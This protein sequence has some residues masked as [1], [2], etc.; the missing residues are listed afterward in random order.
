MPRLTERKRRVLIVDDHPMVREGLASMLEG[1]VGDLFQAGTGEEA[2][3]RVR[4]MRPDLVL[5]DLKL[6]DL[7]GLTVL[8]RIKA[9][10]PETSVVIVTMHDDPEFIRQAVELGAAGYVLKGITRR[11]LVATVGAV[12]EG[13]SVLA[14]EALRRLL[15]GVARGDATGDGGPGSTRLTDV[16]RDVLAMLADGRTNKEI[17][18]HL[19]WSVGSVKKCVQRLLKVLGVSDRTQAAVEAVRRKLVD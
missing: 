11:E 10:A 1:E 16:E 3:G 9:L 2:L 4:E 8:Q 14:R 5:L 12:C 6:P 19:R 18:Q 13:E 17:A 7:D 15:G